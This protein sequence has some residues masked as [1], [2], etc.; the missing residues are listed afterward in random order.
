MFNKCKGVKIKDGILM[1]SYDDVGRW[2]RT[3]CSRLTVAVQFK[4][5]PPKVV[6][7]DGA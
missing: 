1:M 3:H 6:Y 4:Q 2:R 7:R 5:F